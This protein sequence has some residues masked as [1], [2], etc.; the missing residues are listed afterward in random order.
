MKNKKKI[1]IGLIIFIFL[2]IVGALFFIKINNNKNDV[3]EDNSIKDTE[4][5]NLILKSLTIEK[6]QEYNINSFLESCTDN[7][8]EECILSFENEEMAKYKDVNKYVIKIIAKDSA[9]NITTKETTL[10][11]IDSSDTKET[12]KDKQETINKND[13]SKPSTNNVTV[14]NSASNNTNKNTNANNDKPQTNSDNKADKP[15]VSKPQKVN[16]TNEKTTADAYKY[17]T[18]ITK[19]TTTYYDVYSDGSKIKTSSKDEY[20]YD[21]STFNATTNELKEEAISIMNQNI[22]KLNEVLSYVNQYRQEV[23]VEPLVMDNN[24]NIAASIRSLEMGWSRKFS[25]TRPNNSSCFTILNDLNITSYNMGENIAY[26]YT[27]SK[28]VAKGWKESPGHYSNMINN[29]FTKIGIGYAKVN[30]ATYWTQ[31][32]G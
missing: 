7:S 9:N 30:G 15:V 25:H 20:K 1:I 6:G 3:K 17:G 32:F 2:I 13:N 27:T 24:L 22:S 29:N 19:I 26:G 5:P 11:I 18:K 10:E 23:G 31:I 12:S 21:Y 8:N 14:N 4:I 28:T 16:T